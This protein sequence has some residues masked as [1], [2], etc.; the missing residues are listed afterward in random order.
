MNISYAGS[1]SDNYFDPDTQV[2]AMLDMSQF[3]KI[4]VKK[5]SHRKTIR[6]SRFTRN[7]YAI[8]PF[9]TCQITSVNAKQAENNPKI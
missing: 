3:R 6:L 4:S 8:S 5:R 1:Q 2:S 9:K 7:K